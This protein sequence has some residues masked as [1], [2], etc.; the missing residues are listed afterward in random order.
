M[1]CQ[2]G[3]LQLWKILACSRWH[4]PV[5]DM[6]GDIAIGVK[7]QQI[8]RCLGEWLLPS[9]IL[10]I[11]STFTMMRWAILKLSSGLSPHLGKIG[12][13]WLHDGRWQHHLI[14]PHDLRPVT[15]DVLSATVLAK[16]AAA[17]VYAKY[18]VLRC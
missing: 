12:R 2:G 11:V 1:I 17:E 15:S 13:R 18:C 6:G 4:I 3:A 14:H 9:R 5:V 10:P 8:N 7:T 16:D